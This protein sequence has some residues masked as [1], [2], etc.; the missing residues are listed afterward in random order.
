MKVNWT[1]LLFCVGL[2]IAISFIAD[3]AI[4]DIYKQV[5]G[6]ELAKKRLYENNDMASTM[7]RFISLVTSDITKAII[8][9]ILIIMGIGAYMGKINLGLLISFAIGVVA[10]FGAPTVADL[11]APYSDIGAGC[12]CKQNTVIGYDVVTDQ[13]IKTDLKLSPDCTELD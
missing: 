5:D 10:V 6:A 11:L 2:C 1:K 12:K 3:I 9:F 13:K 4:A 8:S 7:C